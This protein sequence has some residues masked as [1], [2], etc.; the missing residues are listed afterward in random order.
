MATPVQFWIGWRFFIGAWKSLRAGAANMDVLVVLGTLAAYLLSAFITI[1][2]PP[3][4]HVYFESAA[5]ITL[6]L[7]GK[8]LESRARPHF[9]RY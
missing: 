5:V 2:D 8:I 6:V 7:L 9:R 4:A 3:G 1:F